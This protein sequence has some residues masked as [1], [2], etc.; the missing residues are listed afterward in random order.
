MKTIVSLYLL[1][2]SSFIFSQQAID[3][4]FDFESD[5]EKKYSLYI[6]SSYVEDEPN[7]LMVALHPWN[8]SRWDAISWRDTL[9]QFAEMNELILLCPDGGVDGQIDDDIDT[10]FTSFLLDSIGHWYNIE[11]S[12]IYLMGFSWGG[13]T[14][15]TYGLRNA[16]KF[17]GFM[18][19][20]A[21]IDGAAVIQ[22]IQTAAFNQN[23]YLVHGNLDS[24]NS[25][26]HPI[27]ELLEENNACIETNL[28]DGVGH[29]IDFPDRN[30]ILTD[31]YQWLA[32]N[33]C[34]NSSTKNSI[35]DEVSI[36]PNPVLRGSEI[37]IDS[38]FKIEA[39]QIKNQ[40]GNKV[41]SSNSKSANGIDRIH[42]E[43][44]PAGIYY[45]E[46]S[47]DERII[48]QKIIVY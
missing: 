42:T 27:V 21:A 36:Y 26:F 8:T 33:E 1:F 12:S 16:D 38:N 29:T 48:S 45:L 40:L 41:F 23:F 32:G 18:P 20:G 31:A 17:A 44:I 25:R 4:S 46:L 7:A 28:L 15:Y 9:I 22:D 24:P 19:I 47:A 3:S 14:S 2:F 35:K 30:A 34:L 11:S 37:N 6:P 10:A 5:P 39:L 43:S 13:L